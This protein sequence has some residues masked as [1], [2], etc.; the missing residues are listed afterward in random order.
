MRKNSFVWVEPNP[1]MEQL[2]RFWYN[3]IPNWY[4]FLR[5]ER[6]K[7]TN[8][9]IYYKMRK[10]DLTEFGFGIKRYREHQLLTIKPIDNQ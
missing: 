8:G 6:F 7:Y 4:R 2:F 9:R 10:K 3:S 1:G 5:G